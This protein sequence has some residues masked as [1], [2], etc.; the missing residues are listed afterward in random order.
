MES[1][2]FYKTT[3]PAAK[4]QQVCGECQSTIE[5][6]V[7]Y[8]Y[9]RCRDRLPNGRTRWINFRTCQACLDQR[10]EFCVD[11]FTPGYLLQDL[12][13]LKAKVSYDDAS[14]WCKITN[15]VAT[16]RKR[17]AAALAKCPPY[18]PTPLRG[19]RVVYGGFAT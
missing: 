15:A 12:E 1:Y 4:N 9:L 14:N 3:M 16:L 18:T 19:P 17:K 11:Y 2:E 6:G 5:E 8:Q 13:A 7:K 10:T